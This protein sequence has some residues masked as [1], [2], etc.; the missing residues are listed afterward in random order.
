MTPMTEGLCRCGCGGRTT[1]SSRTRPER[2]LVKGVHFKYRQGHYP[3]TAETRRKQS[4]VALAKPTEKHPRWKGDDVGYVAAHLWLIQHY[5]KSGIC[6]SC[7][8]HRKTQHAFSGATGSWSRNRD[9]YLEL[10]PSCHK[11]FDLA[12]AEENPNV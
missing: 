4:E 11:R 5:P 9:D 3:R 12:K 10:C 1:V 6:E 2:G 7:G 8:E